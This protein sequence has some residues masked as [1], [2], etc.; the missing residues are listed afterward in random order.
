MKSSGLLRV[1][2][3]TCTVAA[4]LLV[5]PAAHAATTAAAPTVVHVGIANASSDVAF[6]IADKKGYFRQ[7]GIDARFVPFDSGAKMVAPLGA[8]QLDVAG[9]SPSAGL[10]NA[11]VRGIGIKVVADKGS[12]PPG[13]GTPGG[14]PPG[15]RT[16]PAWMPTG[17]TTSFSPWVNWPR[18][19]CATAAEPASSA[20]GPKPI[21]SCAKSTTPDVSLTRWPDADPLTITSSADADC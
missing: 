20:P 17:S 15:T 9:G 1:A 7:E 16:A 2:T 8:G 13:Y 21:T 3:L 11:V 19:A 14:R 4:A 6:F 18:T 10:Y 12:T 5:L